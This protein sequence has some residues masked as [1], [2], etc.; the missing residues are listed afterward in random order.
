MKPKLRRLHSPDMMNLEVD[1][2]ANS[3]NFGVLVQALV[4][5]SDGPGEESF[6]FVVCST[7]Y[8]SGIL[9]CQGFIFGRNYL[10]VEDYSYELIYGAIESLCNSISG[11]TWREI[12]L[13][14][15]QFGKWEF[16]DYVE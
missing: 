12:A 15:G 9:S 14:L 8:L 6:D 4:G 13:K 11:S 10:V 5:P 1:L 7:E 3:K 2:P 16:D